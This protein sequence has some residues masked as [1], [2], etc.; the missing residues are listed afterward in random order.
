[1][2]QYERAFFNKTG[3]CFRLAGS[4]ARHRAGRAMRDPAGIVARIGRF[5]R[6]K[7]SRTLLHFPESVAWLSNS[8]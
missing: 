5:H 8:T 1:M 6:R 2:A 4:F 7:P 3:A